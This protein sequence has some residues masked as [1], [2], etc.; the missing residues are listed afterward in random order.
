MGGTSAQN[1]PPGLF[2]VRECVDLVSSLGSVK[3][4]YNN[5]IREILW[6]IVDRPNR[7]QPVF[8]W[9]KLSHDARFVWHQVCSIVHVCHLAMA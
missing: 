7:W 2:Q 8:G 9:V 4:V 1:V 6:M 3:H 5:A